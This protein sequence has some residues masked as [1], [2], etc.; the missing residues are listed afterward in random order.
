MVICDQFISLGISAVLKT[1]LPK[2]NSELLIKVS[3]SAS[4]T[5]LGLGTCVLDYFPVDN[6][7]MQWKRT[8]II[9]SDKIMGAYKS[10]YPDLETLKPVPMK[11]Y[12]MGKSPYACNW[13]DEIFMSNTVQKAQKLLDY[14]DKLCRLIFILAIF[15][16]VNVDINDEEDKLLK[17]Y[18]E[19]ISIMIY[20]HLMSNPSSSN[21]KCLETMTRIVEIIIELNKMGNILKFG[22]LPSSEENFDN[23]D[24]IEDLVLPDEYLDSEMQNL[25]YH[26]DKIN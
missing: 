1:F 15:S 18:Q 11:N 25:C 5:I 14:D 20:K 16:P 17:Y 13:E 19:K 12:D 8:W 2:L 7:Y 24:E 9:Y 3:Q 21:L 10:A 26:N 23:I 6:L 4:L 22:L